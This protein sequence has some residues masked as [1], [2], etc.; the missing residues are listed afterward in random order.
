VIVSSVASSQRS[1]ASIANRNWMIAPAFCLVAGSLVRAFRN[2]LRVRARKAL[3]SRARTSILRNGE[4]GIA[5][6]SATTSPLRRRCGGANST[7]RSIARSGVKRSASGSSTSGDPAAGG[8]AQRPATGRSSRVSSSA[9]RVVMTL[10]NSHRATRGS[11]GTCARIMFSRGS[12]RVLNR[13]Q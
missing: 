5:A 8:V 9:V 7:T 10:A 11:V 2:A 3:L 4:P 13:W 6:S 12:D 1:L